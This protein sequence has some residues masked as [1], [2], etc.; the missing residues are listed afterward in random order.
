MDIINMLNQL[1][2]PSTIDIIGLS[3]SNISSIINDSNIMSIINTGI[4]GTPHV[5]LWEESTNN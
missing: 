3:N 1:V 2:N 5:L 4:N